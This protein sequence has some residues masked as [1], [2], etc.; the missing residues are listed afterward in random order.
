MS[1]SLDKRIGVGMKDPNGLSVIFLSTVSSLRETLVYHARFAQAAK[2]AKKSSFFFASRFPL[3]LHGI[4]L[5]NLSQ[6]L[7]DNRENC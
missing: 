7:R 1:F 3:R 5:N 2:T 6:S 4:T